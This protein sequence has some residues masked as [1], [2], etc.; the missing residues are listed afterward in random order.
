MVNIRII[1][2][3]YVAGTATATIG[4]SCATQPPENAHRP[5]VNLSLSIYIY[6]YT[7]ICTHRLVTLVLLVIISMMMIIIVLGIVI[8]ATYSTP[9]L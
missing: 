5:C 1:Y 9:P 2:C 7:Y 6:I 4:R 3:I 8:C